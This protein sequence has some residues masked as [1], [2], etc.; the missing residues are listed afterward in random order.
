MI[1]D[2]PKGYLELVAAIAQGV[3]P[4][5]RRVLEFKRILVGAKGTRDEDW[6]E[7]AKDAASM[8]VYGGTL[9]Y[10]VAEDKKQRTFVPSPIELPQGIAQTLDH[11]VASRVDPRPYIM[12]H[13]L[14]LPDD[15]SMGFIVVEIPASQDAPH[16]VGGC[17]YGRSDTG[18]IRLSDVDVERLIRAREAT[19]ARLVREIAET[20]SRDLIPESER[21]VGHFYLTAI[22]SRAPRDLFL[23]LVGDQQAR[24][25]LVRAS[26]ELGDRLLARDRGQRAP[27]SVLRDL[28]SPGYG[29]GTGWLEAWEESSQEGK[30]QRLWIDHDGA[31]RYIYRE[32]TSDASGRSPRSLAAERAG[33]SASARP[34]AAG[35]YDAELFWLTHDL[36][37]F[38]GELSDS[39]KYS[40]TWLLG[41]VLDRAKGC[42]S[43]GYRYAVETGRLFSAG[44]PFDKD[45]Y[46]RTTQATLG[47]L[48]D[49]TRAVAERLMWP[50]LMAL[51]TEDR[52][53]RVES[54]P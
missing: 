48:Q 11:V 13:L 4:A 17:Y 19:E 28:K 38:V 43:H 20:R 39:A 40:G 50:L 8:A 14:P 52:P 25:A 34:V 35:I 53:S 23:R 41:V 3:Y 6:D 46:T 45:E 15:E 47:E 42:I 7:F 36:L 44:N 2:V 9:V 31:V 12:T 26:L 22:P 1:P 51:G 33:G 10:G 24:S 29:S 54:S 18:V 32:A 49:Q 16:Q 21:Q 27:T 37:A 5:E 30:G